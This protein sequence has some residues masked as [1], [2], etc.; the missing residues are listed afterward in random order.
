MTFQLKEDNHRNKARPAFRFEF[1]Q[2][3]RWGESE[4]LWVDCLHRSTKSLRVLR[5]QYPFR[6]FETFHTPV[7]SEEHASQHTYPATKN[8]SEAKHELSCP[9]ILNCVR[10]PKA[11]YHWH[12]P[13]LESPIPVREQCA[14]LPQPKTL[15]S[16]PI[17]QFHVG[18]SSRRGRLMCFQRFPPAIAYN[19]TVPCHQKQTSRAAKLWFMA[20]PSSSSI[21]S[22]SRSTWAKIV[23]VVTTKTFHME[24]PIYVNDNCFNQL[25]VYYYINI[26]IY[27]HVTCLTQYCLN[28]P[29]L[30]QVI[31][32]VAA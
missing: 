1:Q 26:C 23:H 19:P 6:S 2:Y 30:P 28:Y 20:L 29:G 12:L 24:T 21:H 18:T 9:W 8:L 15:K 32:Q 22:C 17:Q 7:Y 5:I 4:I 3:V 11:R 27:T 10:T 13:S 31:G 14:F 16:W 25:Y